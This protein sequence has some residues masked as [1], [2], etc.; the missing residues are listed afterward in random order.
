MLSSFTVG[1]KLWYANNRT[2]C[3]LHYGVCLDT[4][5]AMI[6]Q[7]EIRGNK[8]NKKSFTLNLKLKSIRPFNDRPPYKSKNLSASGFACHNSVQRGKKSACR[9]STRG[10]RL[11]LV[12]VCFSAHLTFNLSQGRAA[13]N[14]PSK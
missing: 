8:G 1:R 14:K 3:C 10:S 7:Y 13:S 2:R 12:L 6:L 9:A 11:L 4:C 5:D